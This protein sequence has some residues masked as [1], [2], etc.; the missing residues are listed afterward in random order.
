MHE[1][2]TGEK[3]EVDFYDVNY[4]FWIELFLWLMFGASW[5]W[6][7]GLPFYIVCGWILNLYNGWLIIIGLWGELSYEKLRYCQTGGY[8]RCT[9]QLEVSGLWNW[10]FYP[11]RRFFV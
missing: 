4:K 3:G 9:L 6:A 8:P 1:D 10:L 7:F 5:F 2:N 11:M